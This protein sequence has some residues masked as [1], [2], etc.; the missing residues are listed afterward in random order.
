MPSVSPCHSPLSQDEKVQAGLSRRSQSPML[1]PT[2]TVRPDYTFGQSQDAKG[3]GMARPAPGLSEVF[4]RCERRHG[5]RSLSL[6]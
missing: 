3:C 5:H 4:V 2:L 1:P 6:R